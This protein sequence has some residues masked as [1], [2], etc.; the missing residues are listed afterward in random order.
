MRADH[1]E[2]LLRMVGADQI[3]VSRMG[4]I[5]ASCPFARATHAGGRDSDPSFVVW[6][7]DSGISSY[8]C[9]ACHIHGASM[10]SMVW[11]LE[12]KG[13]DCGGA[14][15]F[16]RKN[17]LGWSVGRRIALSKFGD[18]DTEKL[19]R[20]TP[21]AFDSLPWDPAQSSAQK[22][23]KPEPMDEASLDRYSP[24]PSQYLLGRGFT[25]ETIM[26]WGLRDD[27]RQQRAVIPVRDRQGVLWGITTRQYGSR[28][29]CGVE[30][31]SWG[32]ARECP[33]PNCGR[34][35][36]PKFLHTAGMHKEL[37]LF[38]EHLLDPAFDRCY[39]FEGH[40]DTIMLWQRGYRNC[41]AM[42]GSSI[43]KEQVKKL[44][45]WFQMV[46]VIPDDDP[47]GH[48]MGRSVLRTLDRRICAVEK[49]PGGGKDPD[50]LSPAELD[51]LLG[52]PQ[53]RH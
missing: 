19:A 23:P 32:G 17:E 2:T 33:N 6:V 29:V 49:Y 43:S 20:D 10:V 53:V 39:L 11:R 1:I 48:D 4:K 24:E 36:P 3:R 21:S 18:K 42:M 40:F 45:D 34:R 8:N 41:L 46:T 14:S 38:G 5:Q 27:P 44:L 15:E 16:A 13:L 47:A 31:K 50:E 52:P 22:A 9:S 51:A 30:F 35:K 37:I 12:T 28:C 26:A 7:N 25:A